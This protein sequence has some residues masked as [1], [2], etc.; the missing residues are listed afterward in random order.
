[1][2]SFAQFFHITDSIS[3][4]SHIV[5]Q[6]IL[7]LSRMSTNWCVYVTVI[8]SYFD[9]I[10][11]IQNNIPNSCRNKMV[12]VIRIHA[13]T[14]L[15]KGF[16]SQLLIWV[17]NQGN[18]VH[19]CS[20]NLVLSGHWRSACILI[21]ISWPNNCVTSVE[22]YNLHYNCHHVEELKEEYLCHIPLQQSQLINP[23][24]VK[25]VPHNW[26]E[27][28]DIYLFLLFIIYYKSELEE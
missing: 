25:F 20:G 18:R 19:F 22:N 6:Q 9:S 23:L 26:M 17:V 2:Y 15:R 13:L 1:M 14:G 11:L 21:I 8:T 24:L 28:H 4:V 3:A 7:S 12:M 27:V 5:T 16:Y 10:S